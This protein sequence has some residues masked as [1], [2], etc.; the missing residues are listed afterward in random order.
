M[1]IHRWPLLALCALAV[2]LAGCAAPP[3]GEPAARL[4]DVAAAV[5]AGELQS[6]ITRLVGFGT[7]HTLSDT[8]SDTRGIGAARR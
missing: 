3:A 7:R 6:T 4:S 1:N 8:R 5:S 2:P